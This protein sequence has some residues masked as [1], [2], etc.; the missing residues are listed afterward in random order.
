M[1]NNYRNA[2]VDLMDSGDDYD[3]EMLG[4]SDEDS[5]SQSPQKANAQAYQEAQAKSTIVAKPP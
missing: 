5:S 4:S 1:K 2:Y 3:T